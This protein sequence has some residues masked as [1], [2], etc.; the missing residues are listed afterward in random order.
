M[1]KIICVYTFVE[2][3]GLTAKKQY[4]PSVRLTLYT[5]FF[6]QV[7]TGLNGDRRVDDCLAVESASNLAVISADFVREPSHVQFVCLR[8]S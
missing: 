3:I 6:M 4:S 8:R 1:S 7:Y 2:I 5:Y